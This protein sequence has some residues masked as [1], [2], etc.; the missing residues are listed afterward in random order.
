MKTSHTILMDLLAGQSTTAALAER[1]R[2]P[3]RIVIAFLQDLEIDGLVETVE[4]GNPSVGRRLVAWRITAAGI[5]L[6]NPL[7]TER[8][9]QPASAI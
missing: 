4:I 9:L 1:L 2:Q 8:R 3:E 7:Q 6:A 5:A